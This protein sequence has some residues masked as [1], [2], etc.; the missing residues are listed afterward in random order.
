MPSPARA[1]CSTGTHSLHGAL[2]GGDVPNNTHYTSIDFEMS[3][4]VVFF[5]ILVFNAL[6]YSI[7]YMDIDIGKN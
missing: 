5:S 6:T 1:S 3:S 4:L 7:Y 2:A